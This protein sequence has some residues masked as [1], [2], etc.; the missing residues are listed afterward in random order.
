MAM[1]LRNY[2]KYCDSLKK[3]LR[4]TQHSLEDIKNN[5]LLAGNVQIL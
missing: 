2:I 4:E 1:E 5:D 3:I